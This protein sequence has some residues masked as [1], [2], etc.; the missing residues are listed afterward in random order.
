MELLQIILESS[1]VAV[2]SMAFGFV[3]VAAFMWVV[4]RKAEKKKEVFPDDREKYD[5]LCY[6]FSAVFGALIEL[7]AKGDVITAKEKM[8][9][10]LEKRPEL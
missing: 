5:L 6:A 10:Y 8:D 1:W 2:V 7:G 3:F 9:C 4:N